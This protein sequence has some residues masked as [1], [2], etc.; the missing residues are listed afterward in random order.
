[1][2]YHAYVWDAA[3]EKAFGTDYGAQAE[4][5]FYQGELQQMQLLDLFN[6]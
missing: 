3:T 6:Q 2:E 5:E 1:M 4:L